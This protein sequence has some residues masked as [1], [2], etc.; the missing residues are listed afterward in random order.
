M[1]HLF[2]CFFRHFHKCQVQYIRVFRKIWIR[3]SIISCNNYGWSWMLCHWYRL[4]FVILIVC[5][6]GGSN[7]RDERKRGQLV[8]SPSALSMLIDRDSCWVC[9]GWW[10]MT[11]TDGVFWFSFHPCL[12]VNLNE[13]KSV[14]SLVHSWWCKRWLCLHGIAKDAEH[15]SSTMFIGDLSMHN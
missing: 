3:I 1:N 10:T 9:H 13:L 11:F 15:C 4:P 6:E 5:Q 14:L 12:Y 8:C 7:R 2:V